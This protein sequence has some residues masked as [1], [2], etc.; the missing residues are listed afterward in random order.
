[1]QRVLAVRAIRG[2]RT[3]STEAACALAGTPPWDLEA[4]VLAE[5]YRR[6]T[7]FRAVIGSTPPKEVRE[8]REAAR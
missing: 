7:E 6:T 4:E 5:E 3:V 8:W 2:Y 1:M